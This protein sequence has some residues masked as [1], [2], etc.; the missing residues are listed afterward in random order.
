MMALGNCGF[1]IVVI[2]EM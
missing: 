1:S 2:R